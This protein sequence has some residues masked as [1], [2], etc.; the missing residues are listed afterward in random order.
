MDIDKLQKEYTNETSGRI[1]DEDNY[2]NGRG[3]YHDDYVEWLEQKL[4]TLGLPSVSEPFICR[5]CKSTNYKIL[6]RST[7]QCKDCGYA[8]AN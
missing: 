5:S 8:Q 6:T 4:V 1:K 7:S 3:S 2:L